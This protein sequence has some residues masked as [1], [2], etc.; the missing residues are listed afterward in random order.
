[1]AEHLTDLKPGESAT[2]VALEGG[3]GMQ[4]RLRRMGLVE[5]RPIRKLS[6]LALGGPVVVMVDRAQVAVGRGLARRIEV[7]RAG[8]G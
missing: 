2:I 7:R 8:D 6:A 3:R 1:M 5:G 4:A